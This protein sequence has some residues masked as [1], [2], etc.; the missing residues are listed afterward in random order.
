MTID[1]IQR[2]KPFILAPQEYPQPQLIDDLL[3]NLSTKEILRLANEY[4]L[5]KRYYAAGVE[6]IKYLLDFQSHLLTREESDQYDDTYSW[7]SNMLAMFNDSPR[8]DQIKEELR[9]KG[10]LNRQDGRGAP[11]SWHIPVEGSVIIERALV[12]EME[13][14]HTLSLSGIAPGGTGD[15][16]LGVVNM[17]GLNG[18]FIQ[19]YSQ[20]SPDVHLDIDSVIAEHWVAPG[21]LL[22]SLRRVEDL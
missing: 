22:S 20:A 2:L 4:F 21:E 19:S 3:P 6:R 17:F 1:D 11:L 16:P 9:G 5:G 8:G 18:L 14:V 15:S 7:Y 13:S 12:A 10:V